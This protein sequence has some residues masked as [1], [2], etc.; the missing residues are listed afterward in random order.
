[1]IST[2]RD[3][4]KVNTVADLEQGLA[5][6]DTELNDKVEPLLEKLRQNI[7]STDVTSVQIHM[8][9]VEAWRVRLVKYLSLASAFVEHAKDSTFL[10]E[11]HK[12][13]GDSEKP[14]R[15]PEI[16]RDAYRRKMSGGFVALQVYLEGL[17][18]SV[19]SRVNLCK[20]VLGIEV[21]GQGGQKYV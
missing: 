13:N 7:L 16:E 8:A 18:Y 19:D 20:K 2:I 14:T 9:Y 3:I 5:Q 1:M 15:V 6:F 12:D 10:A 17:I 4:F 21:E 11:K